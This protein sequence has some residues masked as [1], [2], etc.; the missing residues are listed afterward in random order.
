MVKKDSIIWKS[1]DLVSLTVVTGLLLALFLYTYAYR[2][3][4]PITIITMFL[5]GAIILRQTKEIKGA[6][7]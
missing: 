6:L 1:Y 5:M 4:E 3:F 7:K 2:E